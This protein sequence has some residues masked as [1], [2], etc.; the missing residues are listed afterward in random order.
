MDILDFFAATLDTAD[1]KDIE[2]KST[3][4]F[5]TLEQYGLN[6]TRFRPFCD[7]MG[8]FHTGQIGAARKVYDRALTTKFQT[9]CCR[10]MRKSK[11]KKGRL[12]QI[13]SEFAKDAKLDWKEV[14]CAP[15][16]VKIKEILS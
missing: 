16:V 5:K 11:D 8:A 9:L 2:I 3:K 7:E 13:I 12:L 4:V 6:A 14:F 15:L 10:A 1:T